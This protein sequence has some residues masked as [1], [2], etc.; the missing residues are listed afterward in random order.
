MKK[1]GGRCLAVAAFMVCCLQFSASA[2]HETSHEPVFDQESHNGST[3]LVLLDIN[4]KLNID[5]SCFQPDIRSLLV[6]YSALWTQEYINVASSQRNSS[7][8]VF[9]CCGSP[10]RALDILLREMKK[11]DCSTTIKGI[12]IFTSLPV[13]SEM[14]T[15]LERF[16]IPQVIIWGELKNPPT[17][18]PFQ[19]FIR[20]KS[21]KKSKALVELSESLSWTYINTRVSLSADAVEEHKSFIE[22]AAQSKTRI[23][24]AMEETSGTN[25]PSQASTV[26]F[27]NN[28]L[29]SSG[30]HEAAKLSDATSK[31]TLFISDSNLDLKQIVLNATTNGLLLREDLPPLNNIPLTD[32]IVNR[33]NLVID[34]ADEISR[35][36]LVQNSFCKVND[37]VLEDCDISGIEGV[38]SEALNLK[39]IHAVNKALKMIHGD[40]NTTLNDTTVPNNNATNTTTTD[41]SWNE[42]FK[43]SNVSGIW[44]VNTDF[45]LFA[46]VGPV[47]EKVGQINGSFY[48]LDKT[49]WRLISEKLHGS[50]CPGYCPTCI[51]CSDNRTQLSINKFEEGDFYIALKLPI[52]KSLICDETSHENELLADYFLKTLREMKEN[53]TT[54]TSRRL[55]GI[56]IDS[57][58]SHGDIDNTCYSFIDKNGIKRDITSRNLLSTVN[59]PDL[60]K[61]VKEQRRNGNSLAPSI[62]ITKI[63]CFYENVNVKKYVSVILDVLESLRWSY[64][65][66]LLSENPLMKAIHLELAKQAKLKN[67][68]IRN[69]MLTDELKKSQLLNGNTLFTGQDSPAV[70]LLTDISDTSEFLQSISKHYD[71]SHV[72]NL[73]FFS[74]NSKAFSNLGS[75]IFQS[76]IFI[77]VNNPKSYEISRN[78]T[79]LNI[80]ELESQLEMCHLSPSGKIYCPAGKIV[81]KSEKSVY[82]SYLSAIMKTTDKALNSVNSELCPGKNDLCSEFQNWPKVISHFHDNLKVTP[83][84]LFGEKTHF[85][86][87]GTLEVNFAMKNLRRV[88]GEFEWV[89]VGQYTINRSISLFKKSVRGYKGLKDVKAPV[90]ECNG[91]CPQCYQ[92]DTTL[93]KTINI[94][95][96]FIYIPGDIILTAMMPVRQAGVTTFECGDVNVENNVDQLVEAI[97][98]AVKTFKKR[99]NGVLKNIKIGLLIFDTCSS[100]QKALSILGNFESC[101]YSIR[102]NDKENSEKVEKNADYYLNWGA[103]PKLTPAYMAVGSSDVLDILLDSIADFKKPVIAIEKNGGTRRAERDSDLHETNLSL[104]LSANAR[105]SAIIS[106]INAYRWNHIFVVASD[107]FGNRRMIQLFTDMTKSTKICIIHVIWLNDNPRVNYNGLSSNNETNSD[108]PFL[109]AVKL[110]TTDNTTKVVVAF[111][112]EDHFTKLNL[113]INKSNLSVIWFFDQSPNGWEKHSLETSIPY[114]SF[115]LDRA[116]QVYT[117]F[118]KYYNSSQR[119]TDN[120]WFKQQEQK[121]LSCQNKNHKGLNK[122]CEGKDIPAKLSI[123]PVT[124]DVIRA[125]D[126]M[127]YA[128]HKE[129]LGKCG[130]KGGLC[131]KFNSKNILTMDSFKGVRVQFESDSFYFDESQEIVTRIAI[132]NHVLDENTTKVVK[133]AE[134][135]DNILYEES[136]HTLMLFDNFGADLDKEDVRLMM[137]ASCEEKSCTCVNMPPKPTPSMKST[138]ALTLRDEGYVKSTG[139]FRG[140]IWATVVITVAAAG[141]LTAIGIFTYLLYKYCLGTGCGRRYCTLALILLFALVVQ[142]STILPFVFTPNELVCEMRYFAPAFGYAFTLSIILVKLMNLHDYRLIGLGGTLSIVN[143]L[144]TIV[145]ITGIQVAVGLQRWLLMKSALAKKVTYYGVSIYSC[146]FDKFEF[147]YYICYPMFLQLL[148]L[149]YAISLYKEK[150]NLREAKYILLASLLSIVVWL[151][152]QLVYFLQPTIFMQPAVAIGILIFTTVNLSLIFIPKIHMMA[153]LR[154]DVNKTSQDHYS[155]KADSDFFF[156]RPF[157]LPGTLKT[158]VSEKTYARSY[159]AFENSNFSSGSV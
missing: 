101:I 4:K 148:I 37:E 90:S 8:K 99:H 69:V 80:S 66:V 152:W 44:E 143:Q 122:P 115:T 110:L 129:Y 109:Q 33:S 62:H 116:T 139:Q 147:I 65:T 38:L 153:T 113:L 40:T 11:H 1:S 112:S 73:V 24:I 88:N 138:M 25:I 57:C 142:Y 16:Q 158:S 151:S 85:D 135:K 64:L 96:D 39:S 84:F 95:N 28:G 36:W 20:L 157:S 14:K 155:T 107:T 56:V 46:T 94:D 10:K 32:F 9:D 125:A 159:D 114:G 42:V 124:T 67:I 133:V 55:G 58:N 71:S 81:K 141:V 15:Y 111:I 149:L 119:G 52:Q 144:L 63:G 3:T 123:S 130:G 87:S 97:I 12:V 30:H 120:V 140:S 21:I 26:I 89:Q 137:E 41:D 59:V 86:E 70:I 27:F 61:D 31:I 146:L 108:D 53:P 43:L 128:I 102:Q 23:C 156:E 127:L 48:P 49:R 103:S 98:Y 35:Q 51:Q 78:V 2:F 72:F 106:L 100:K 7:L 76:S 117:D 19:N 6:A 34:K 118:S 92:C 131:D 136:K 17:P 74:W 18:A 126:A 60:E 22:E 47:F 150:R 79:S 132:Y 91:W 54:S 93:G 145:F 13:F 134:W 75:N 29:T 104:A 77:E 121:R 45:S 68:C 50:R 154:Y 105:F 82:F 83:V 5:G